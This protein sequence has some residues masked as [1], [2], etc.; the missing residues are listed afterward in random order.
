MGR[1]QSPRVAATCWSAGTFAATGA[2]S[3]V[4][5]M[6]S[7]TSTAPEPNGSR[8]AAQGVGVWESDLTNDT[9]GSFVAPV[10]K[11]AD[12]VHSK[13]P[14]DIDAEMA[15]SLSKAPTS[16]MRCQQEALFASYKWEKQRGP[17][18]ISVSSVLSTSGSTPSHVHIDHLPGIGSTDP[19]GS[20]S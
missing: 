6:A 7:R 15:V 1:T 16:R 10:V 8:P 5:S 17:W 13:A 19:C 20:C 4:M 14:P 18:P 9:Q 11:S 12:A 2:A 3:A